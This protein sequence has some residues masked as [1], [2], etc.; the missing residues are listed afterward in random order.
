MKSIGLVGLGF[1]GKTHLQAFDRIDNAQVTAICTKSSLKNREINIENNISIVAEYDELLANNE[2][3]IID[4]CLPTFLHEE[5]IV[6]AL[7]AGK[8]VICEK[9]LTLNLKSAERILKAVKENK[10]QLFVGHVLRFWPEY[11]VIKSYSENGPLRNIEVVHAQRLGQFPTWSNWF[12]QPDLSG[13]A[14]FDLHIH[15][16]DF[17]YYL[18]GE[19]DSVYSIGSQNEYGAWDHVMSTL[20]FKNKSMAFVEASQRMSSGYPFTMSFRAQNRESLLELNIRAGENIESINDSKNQLLYYFNEKVSPIEIQG[21]DAFQKELAYFVNCI[22]NEK[23]NDII[24]L[25]QVVY[26]L[27]LLEAVQS[28]L[29]EKKVVWL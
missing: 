13:G 29:E 18:L 14:L 10:M 11:E 1:I 16:I 7:N 27:K 17:V 12:K 19:V 4:I 21:Y 24:P 25:E 9:P 15:D 22:E 26:T 23:V 20:T 6:K 5:Y 8:H 2:I 28:S 3:D